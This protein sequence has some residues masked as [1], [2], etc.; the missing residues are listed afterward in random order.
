MLSIRRFLLTST[1]TFDNTEHVRKVMNFES[2]DYVYTRGNNPT[3]RDFETK[4][5]S[6]ENGQ[7]AVAFASG[8][9]AITTTLFSLLK[10]GD[11]ALYHK[12]LYGSSHTV[13]KKNVTCIWRGNRN[14]QLV[15]F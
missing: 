4:M 1:F 6:L 13:L 2:D 3:L 5:S 8:M 11:K 10:P 14:G 9:A 15:R 12:T 7:G